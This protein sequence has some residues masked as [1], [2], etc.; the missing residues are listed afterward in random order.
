MS[1]EL[2]VTEQPWHQ[3]RLPISVEKS[4]TIRSSRHTE[5]DFSDAVIV[6]DLLAW[7][8][9]IG[10]LASLA[11]ERQKITKKIAAHTER[12]HAYLAASTEANLLRDHREYFSYRIRTREKKIRALQTTLE[13]TSSLSEEDRQK[14]NRRLRALSG[15]Q[16]REK[17]LVRSEQIP[18]SHTA[19]IEHTNRRLAVTKS[20]TLKSEAA[21][22][23]KASTVDAK[24]AKNIDA[25]TSLSVVRHP[26]VF[27]R[28]DGALQINYET[29]KGEALHK[30]LFLLAQR[31]LP[32]RETAEVL[33][34]C[35]V[36]RFVEDGEYE[37]LAHPEFQK[38]LDDFAGQFRDPEAAAAIKKAA[39]AGIVMRLKN[40]D[41][42]S[43]GTA[44]Y[45]ADISAMS[46]DSVDR[47]FEF[48]G[49]VASLQRAA[50]QE[51]RI[52]QMRETISRV[53][54]PDYRA[55]LEK[56]YTDAVRALRQKRGTVDDAYAQLMRSPFLGEPMMRRESAEADDQRKRTILYHLPGLQIPHIETFIDKATTVGGR[57]E[58]SSTFAL[59]HLTEGAHAKAK[60]QPE[61]SATQ[62]RIHRAVIENGRFFDNMG[63]GRITTMAELQRE[64]EEQE[65]E[66]RKFHFSTSLQGT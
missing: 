18:P 45:D 27:G 63:E 39:I 6:H 38:L 58:T 47:A 66:A 19:K 40:R 56:R 8:K 22:E 9:G 2:A 34:R 23:K 57:R 65:K 1:V 62:E 3:G 50:E 35:V 42:S 29:E 15:W 25:I 61:F 41:S 21:L 36:D 43:R 59:W 7:G 60:K 64:R 48:F 5:G 31:N 33:A 49:N 44:I 55:I 14:L 51:A 37:R 28:L 13:T 17:H 52:R 46:G 32:N 20:Y 4:V 53:T 16:T 10:N 24:I 12:R 26:A 11:T 54:D 30:L